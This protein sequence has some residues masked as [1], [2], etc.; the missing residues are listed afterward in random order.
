MSKTAIIDLRD[1]S[2]V[3][4]LDSARNAALKLVD[5]MYG[6]PDRVKITMAFAFA[7]LLMGLSVA[8]QGA[9]HMAA[10]PI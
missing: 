9:H 4:A 7:L 5:F 3:P 10:C 1:A 6:N 2:L 8:Q